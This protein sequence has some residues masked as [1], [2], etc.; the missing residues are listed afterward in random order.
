LKPSFQT[1]FTT[2]GSQF[3]EDMI[4]YKSREGLNRRD[5]HDF[6]APEFPNAAGGFYP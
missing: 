5:F 3:I 6:V 4:I 2:D 1:R